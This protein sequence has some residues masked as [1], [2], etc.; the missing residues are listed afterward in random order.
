M[1]QC[2][3]EDCTLFPYY[4]PLAGKQPKGVIDGGSC[5]RCTHI[6]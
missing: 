5:R 1:H 4:K 3:T 2:G 6:T